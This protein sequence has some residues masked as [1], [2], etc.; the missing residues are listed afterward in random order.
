MLN[1]WLCFSSF[2]TVVV[3]VL[4]GNGWLCTRHTCKFLQARCSSWSP[5]FCLYPGYWRLYLYTIFISYH[6][7]VL[8]WDH[9]YQNRNRTI[10]QLTWYFIVAL[11]N[12]ICKFYAVVYKVLVKYCRPTLTSCVSVMYIY[13]CKLYVIW[14]DSVAHVALCCYRI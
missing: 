1:W 9:H 3:S 14:D 11:L 8:L 4:K 12:C 6:L 7:S 5:T 2:L 13:A 10:T